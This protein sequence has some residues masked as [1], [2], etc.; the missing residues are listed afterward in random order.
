MGNNKYFITR[1]QPKANHAGSKAVKDTEVIL[2][3]EGYKRI[4]IY[5]KRD[6]NPFVRKL[7]NYCSLSGI[8]KIPDNSI[9][10]VEHPLYISRKYM[11]VLKKVKEK[12][13]LV[14]AFLIHDFETIR[15]L[16][17]DD[18]MIRMVEKELLAVADYIIVHNQKMLYYF[19]DK[20]KFPEDHLID[21]GIFDYLCE[22]NPTVQTDSDIIIAGNL[23]PKKSGY[24]Y[25]L[26]DAFPEI[27]I[28]L[29]GVNYDAEEGGKNCSYKGS[30]DADE[31]P[32]VIEGRFGLVWDGTST[33][34]CDGATGRYLTVNNP[35]K[36]S[37]YIAAEKPIIIWKK[38]ALADFVEKKGIGFTVNSLGEIPKELEKIDPEK[39]QEYVSNIKK[40]SSNVRDGYYL[41]KALNKLEQ[42]VKTR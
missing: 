31:I 40:L 21:L 1:S 6:G 7:T 20:F 28:N 5:S 34:V 30:V 36:V 35:H 38:A 8:K 22:G 2:E 26:T 37:L 23:N 33:D 3:A 42:M 25:K 27:S 13:K 11:D 41:K 9:V 19:R 39:Y 24:I 16:F 14:I 4:N 10:V 17:P 32:N 29:Y 12:K 18:H 15:G